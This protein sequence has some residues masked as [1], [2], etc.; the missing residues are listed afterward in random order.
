MAADKPNVV[1]NGSPGNE[2]G[3]LPGILTQIGLILAPAGL[4]ALFCQ[5]LEASNRTTGASSLAVVFLTSICIYRRPINRYVPSSILTGL[6]VALSVVFFFNYQNLLL[7]DTGLIKW[8]RQSNQF[9]AEIDPEL[10]RSQQEVWFFGTN[11]NISVG[12]HR[13]LLLRKLSTGIDIRYL[14]FDPK[15]GQLDEL[16]ADFNQSPAELRAECEKGLESI[17]ELQ[18]QWKSQSSTVPRPGE[19]QV[20]VF[21]A[22][23]HARFYIFDPGSTE[24]NT[25]FVPYVNNLNSPNVP[26]YLLQNIPKGVFEQYFDGIRKL[27]ARSETLEQHQNN[28]APVH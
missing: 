12:E 13:D 11:F 6:L 16:A 25:L 20:R 21:D 5:V 2:G 28:H 1:A 10:E 22:H 19:L 18:K 27:W 9:L 14:I 8:Y 17:V 26:G 7:K 3:T 24:G 23:P 15:S 4:V